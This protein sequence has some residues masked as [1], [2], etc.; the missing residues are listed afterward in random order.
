MT[1]AAGLENASNFYWVLGSITG[2]TPGTPLGTVTLPLT[3]PD[4]YFDWT[5]LN[6]NAPPIPNSVGLLDA[7]GNAAPLFDFGPASPPGLAG[8]TFYHAAIVVD[9][10]LIGLEGITMVTNPTFATLVP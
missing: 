10:S 4:P 8:L 5:L 9:A 1:L 3:S 6:Y 7:S 2:T